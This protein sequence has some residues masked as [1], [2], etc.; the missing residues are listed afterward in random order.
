MSVID[1]SVLIPTYNRKLILQKTISHICN[2]TFP[3]RKYEVVIIDDYSKDGSQEY[4]SNLKLPLKFTYLQNGENLGRAKTR[5]RGLKVA[6]GKYVLMIDDDLW[7]RQDLL[8]EHYKKHERSNKDVAVVGAILVAA[9]I[10]KT[11]VNERLNDHHLW[12]Y[13]EMCKS[14]N[15]LPYTFCKT[16]NLSLPSRLLE[17]IGLFNE[18]FIHYGGE[19]TEFGYRLSQN[20]INLI[21][22]QNAVAYHFHN[23]TVESLIAKE[24]ERAKTYY[25]YRQLHP[26]HK[27]DARAFFSPFYHKGFDVR[28]MLYNFVKMILFMP[29][30]RHMNKLT[31]KCFNES[32]MLRSLLVKYL[33]PILQTQYSQYGIKRAMK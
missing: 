7:A 20:N 8:E 3:K 28:T 4:L 18:S 12:C 31:I 1:I 5:N 10:P 9:E 6:K 33:I 23:E 24:I 30:S 14:K 16:A 32:P 15:H 2:Q 29:L 27:P 17:K 11:S 13:D 25:I 22:A 26:E 19:D 21:F